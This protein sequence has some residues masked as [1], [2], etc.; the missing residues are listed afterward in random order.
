M[1]FSRTFG[2]YRTYVLKCPEE[3]VA[4]Y[5]KR[6]LESG[7]A[8]QHKDREGDDQ[9][10]ANHV[11][12]LD[13]PIPH[14]KADESQNTRNTTGEQYPSDRCPDPPG[15]GQRKG[16]HPQGCQEMK[17][18]LIKQPTGYNGE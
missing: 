8:Y 6:G 7:A 15:R 13:K 4:S 5:R 2:Y 18:V 17:G 1:T 16:K 10:P 9:Y 3:N 12:Q 14:G 11:Q